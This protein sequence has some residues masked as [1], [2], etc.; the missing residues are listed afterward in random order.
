MATTNLW[1][2]GHRPA[3]A[4]AAAFQSNEKETAPIHYSQLLNCGSS[5]KPQSICFKV[6]NNIC[7]NGECTS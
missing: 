1:F 7:V 4:A 5:S 2:E 6:V 3:A